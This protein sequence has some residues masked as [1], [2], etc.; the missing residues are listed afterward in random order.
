MS[1]IFVLLV[2]LLCLMAMI[3]ENRGVKSFFI[4]LMNF[5]S[6]FIM[7]KAVAF[8]IDP[9]KATILECII[10][11]SITLFFINGFNRKSAAAFIS[12]L[13]VVIICILFAYKTGTGAKLQGFSN[14]NPGSAAYL[15]YYVHVNFSKLVTCEILIGLLGG[16]IDV[17]ISIS[18]AMNEVFVNTFTISKRDLFRSGLNIGRD[19]LGAM[20]NTLLFAYLSGFMPLLIWLNMA[21]Y[22]FA[23]LINSKLFCPEV[24][25]IICSGI[26]IVLIIP[27]TAAITTSILLFNIHTIN[28][29]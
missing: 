14:E 27:V 24:F 26:G 16:I 23:D 29:A 20:T 18:S 12:V 9:I 17:A 22:S 8:G 11:S 19:I 3:G 5:C 1:I 15:S 25:Q 21:E 7:L 6:F 2:V 28:K 4:L 13:I 10:I